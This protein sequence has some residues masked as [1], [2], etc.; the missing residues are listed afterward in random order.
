M[1]FF[2]KESKVKGLNCRMCNRMYRSALGLL[3]HIEICGI[4][5]EEKLLTRVRCE[6]CENEFTK[7][8]IKK[9]MSACLQNQIELT[10][11]ANKLSKKN[12]NNVGR[13]KRE[14]VLK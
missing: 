2:F 14:S 4:T 3:S 12:L 9:H 10:N 11:E 13:V 7:H 5:E 1:I 6:F 8:T